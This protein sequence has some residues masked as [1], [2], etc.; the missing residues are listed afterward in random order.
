MFS[1]GLSS[2]LERTKLNHRNATYVLAA[3]AHSLGH[4][5]DN[6]HKGW[7]LLRD[8]TGKALNERPEPDDS[9]M[10]IQQNAKLS[11]TMAIEH[12]IQRTIDCSFN[13]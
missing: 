12:L 13:V 8:L 7:R 3:A 4:N 6:Y 9:P 2:A 10:R 1:P 11:S 5:E